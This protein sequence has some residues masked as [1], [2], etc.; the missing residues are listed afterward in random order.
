M[1]PLIGITTSNL[2]KERSERIGFDHVEAVVQAGGVPILLSNLVSEESD[3][4]QIVQK[5]DGLYV[6]GGPDIDPAYFDEEPIPKLGNISPLRDQFEI[7][8]TKAFLDLNKPILG[9]CRGC[10]VLN[11]ATGGSLYQD[12]YSQIDRD[13]L[14]HRQKA[15]KSHRVHN[16]NVVAD[17]LLHRLTGLTEFKVN[18]LHHQAVKKAVQPIAI[19]GTAN[20][21]V[22]EAIESSDNAFVLGV[23]W[24]PE[25]TAIVG[26]EPSV[27]IYQGF[28][29]A[30]KKPIL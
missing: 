30:C 2:M 6:T 18:T 24:H 27:K 15:P 7:A 11:V 4:S 9:V 22:I 12:L 10:Q 19:S 29:D 3:I 8:I 14:Q 28:I 20:D 13:L 23:Q 21:G 1:K 16:V 25:G 26:D 17:S 5:I